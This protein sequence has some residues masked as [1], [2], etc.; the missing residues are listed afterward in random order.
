MSIGVN[1]TINSDGTVSAGK[2]A[3]TIREKGKSLTSIPDN[4]TVIDIETTGLD[5]KYDEIIEI[6]AI[7]IRNG[8]IVDKFESLIK[9]DGYLFYDDS[10]NEHFNYVDEFITE[11]TGIT[12]DML[13]QAPDIK[14]VL[15]KFIEF[16]QDDILVGHN[17][18][19]D[20]NF[21]YDNL[22]TLLNFKLQNNFVDLM[23][24]TRK[25][26]SEFNN[27]KL[28]TIATNL[29][30]DINNHH[31]ALGDCKITYECFLKLSDHINKNNIELY[32]S[33]KPYKSV[34]LK[35]LKSNSNS[36]DEEHLL[37]NKYCTFTGKLEKIDR[38]DAAQLVVNLGGKCLNNIT[39]QTNFLILGNFDY[40]S[41]V[42]GGKSS[43]LKK[44]EKLI[45]SGQDLQVLSENVFYDLI[46]SK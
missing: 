33:F 24:L 29:G 16:I 12:N 44:A 35:E 19:F 39:K 22:Y 4:Y 18:N 11:L 2:G 14:D 27:H 40:S 32:N 9:P 1:I 36:F 10:D 17:I 28:I 42:K 46:N 25:I 20:I 8:M 3:V 31:R 43:K 23:R 26:Y 38:K 37:Y 30:L 21:L 41:N 7:R 45:L 15:P 34:D 5:P 6:G 13:H